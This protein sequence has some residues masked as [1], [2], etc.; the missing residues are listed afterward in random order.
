M[1]ELVEECRT[2]YRGGL[3]KMS[4]WLPALAHAKSR[5]LQHFLKV[6]IIFN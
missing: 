6:A 4:D 2:F 5:T 1:D 3:V